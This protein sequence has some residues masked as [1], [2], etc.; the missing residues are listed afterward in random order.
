MKIT[1]VE[2]YRLKYETAVLP[3]GQ[4]F[5]DS[6]VV[7]KVNTDEGI[8]GYGEAA[9]SWGKAAPAA[10]GMIKDL[11]GMI[12]GMDPMENEAIWEKM[13]KKSFWGQAGGTII[14]AAMSALDIAVW[15]IKGKALGVPV[16]K[17]LGGKI[18]DNLRSYASQLQFDWSSA[19]KVIIEPQEYA[20]AALKA[21]EDGYDSI[22]LD[23]IRIDEKGGGSWDLTKHISKDIM[24]LS[25]DR[26]AAMRDAVGP[27][28]DIILDMHSFTDARTAVQFGKAV[29]DI[30]IFYYEEPVMPLN[31]NM[32]KNV[33]DNV[34]IPIAA[35]ERIYTRW[36]YRPFFEMNAL[37]IIQPDVATCGGFTEAKKICD[38]A[39]IYDVSVQAHV[40]GSPIAV[41]AGLH[42]EAA[43]PNFLIHEHNWLSIIPSN[44]EIG[45][46]DY[47]PENG[48][49]KIPELPGIGQELSEAA[50]KYVVEQA[51]VE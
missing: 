16:Y 19:P 21:V 3:N 41:A 35:G 36:G 50:M 38:M 8:T 29:E 26:L 15:D 23:P 43:I 31:P 30:G 17:L 27:D 13:F 18:N 37:D 33:R 2:V 51:I 40:C 1:S 24:K 45:K 46:Y 39:H 10:V 47:Q 20:E 7:C 22:K 11:A 25:Y 12:I 4:R 44:I 32:M 34:N 28:V 49:F 42:L 6:P 5:T 9:V 48:R 14:S